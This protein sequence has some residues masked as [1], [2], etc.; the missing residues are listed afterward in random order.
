MKQL[1]I[2][3]VG[4]GLGNIAVA[5]GIPDYPS[6]VNGQAISGFLEVQPVEWE[7]GEPINCIDKKY[8]DFTIFECDV[9][10]SQLTF[11]LAPSRSISL[12]KMT[13]I[14]NSALGIDEYRFFGNWA[15]SGSPSSEAILFL[16]RERNSAERGM[17]GSLRVSRYN[18]QV[19]IE[20]E[21][22]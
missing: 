14:Y 1:F 4:M 15:S 5:S 7:A 3:L 8:A 22:P 2:L 16:R 21:S 6:S 19:G 18:I 20:L 13:A 10:D 11:S 12:T 9:R 17:W